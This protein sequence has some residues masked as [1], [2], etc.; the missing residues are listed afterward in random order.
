MAGAVYKL[1]KVVKFNSEI[2]QGVRMLNVPA[3]HITLLV[4]FIY[5]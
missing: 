2:W 5:Y 1:K 3:E 4:V